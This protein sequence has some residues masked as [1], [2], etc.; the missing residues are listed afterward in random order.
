MAVALLSL[1]SRN[2]AHREYPAGGRTL[3]RQPPPLR[4]GVAMPCTEPAI[5]ARPTIQVGQDI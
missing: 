5:E 3:V 4:Q 1:Q 2:G